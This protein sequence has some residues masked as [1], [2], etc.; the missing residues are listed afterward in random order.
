VGSDE[1]DL[2][3]KATRMGF[4]ASLS[5]PKTAEELA[6]ELF[7][8]KEDGALRRHKD[9]VLFYVST[10]AGL[11]ILGASLLLVFRGDGD[12]TKWARDIVAAFVT[13]YLGYLVGRQRK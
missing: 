10:G 2:A 8:A 4:T 11:I 6:A 7:E 3:E 9:K 1:L 13:A 12:Q 5:T